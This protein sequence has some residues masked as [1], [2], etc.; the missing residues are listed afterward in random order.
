MR[1]SRWPSTHIYASHTN[2]TRDTVTPLAKARGKPVE[3]FPRVGSELD[4][5]I[6][7]NRTAGNAAIMPLIAAV[8]SLPDTHVKE[9]KSHSMEPSF[10][11]PRVT[12]VA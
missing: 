7:D 9:G 11:S 8:R 2:R 1:A 5:K 12:R 6:V 3:Q 4:G 10:D